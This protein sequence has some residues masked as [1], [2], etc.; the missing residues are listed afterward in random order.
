LEER[1]TQAATDNSGNGIPKGAEAA[2]FHRRAGNIAADS[3]T[4]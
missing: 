1:A 4:D 2:L 3:A